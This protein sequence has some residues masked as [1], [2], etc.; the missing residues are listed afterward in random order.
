MP[1]TLFLNACWFH[2]E[3]EKQNKT[4]Q[5][6]HTHTH[7]TKP[8]NRLLLVMNKIVFNILFLVKHR[9]HFRWFAQTGRAT[10]RKRE[11]EGGG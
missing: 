10:E 2:S 9:N 6:T 8:K 4:T 3:T 1:M 11:K 7:T 5:N